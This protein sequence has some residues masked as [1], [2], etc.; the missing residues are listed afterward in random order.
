[1]NFQVIDVVDF[2]VLNRSDRICINWSEDLIA[3]NVATAIDNN[4]FWYSVKCG[5]IDA[6]MFGRVVEESVFYVDA[7]L[8]MSK[9]CIGIM[10]DF[11]MTN[12]PQ[13]TIIKAHRH[14]KRHATYNLKCK[15]SQRR[16][17]NLTI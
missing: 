7:L 9:G 12:H 17:R 11:I 8:S 1:M 4:C 13:C 2:V 15:K 5:Y 10:A 14:E 16:F 3:S 6:V